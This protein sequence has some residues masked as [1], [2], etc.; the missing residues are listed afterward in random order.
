MRADGRTLAASEYT[1]AWPA[2]RTAVGAYPVKVT[3]RGNYSGSNS[4][5]F[6]ILPKATSLSKLKAAKK[7]FTAKWKKQTTQVDGYRL[8]YSLKKTFKGA[9]TVTVKKAKTVSKKVKKLKSKKK[10]Y[11]RIG[12]FKKAGGVTYYSSWSKAKA[13][14]TK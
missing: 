12:T 5:T 10:Y 1:V 13:V 9:K 8:Q 4:A 14:K 7:G 2:G 6:T 11:V 3:L